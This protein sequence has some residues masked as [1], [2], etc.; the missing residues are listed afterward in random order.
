M[1]RWG[2]VL[3]SMVTLGVACS[4]NS[5]SSKDTRLASDKPSVDKS[6]AANPD[7]S[8][9]AADV[10]PVSPSG[11]LGSGSTAG[12]ADK[13]PTVGVKG[14][15]YFTA[16]MLPVLNTNCASC[17]ADPRIQAAVRGPL[18]IFSF[19]AMRS[20]LADG[21]TATGNAFF[22]K[23]R[24][25][26]SHGGGDRCP[27]GANATPCKEFSAWW[28]V[29]V[30]G[31]STGKQPTPAGLVSNISSV[32]DFG[33]VYGY[34]YNPADVKATVSV[35]FYVDGP[36][37]SGTSAGTVMANTAGDDANADGDH[38]FA[39][40]L[41]IN[42]R[43][44]KQHKLYAYGLDQN[45]QTLLTITPVTFTAYAFTA[46]GRSF[47]DAT[48]KPKLAGCAS[49]HTIAYEQQ[50]YTLMAPSPASG[51]TAANND[52]INKPA[53]ANNTKHGG[54]QRCSSVTASP[55]AELQ[56]WWKIEAGQ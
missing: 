22:L 52:L 50:Y 51:A 14:E 42:L 37:G 1:H 15:A 45:S 23:V 56:A 13:G 16:T 11:G 20:K 44:G 43:D 49:C 46:A 6:S 48:V 21:A 3:I 29:E 34:A 32:S 30:G 18:T 55:C 31:A 38:A 39:Y 7:P 10:A 12:S 19:A 35:A 33:R 47:F 41:P 24:N 4:T 54:G 5:T 28:T 2:L 8:K 53:Q 36:S 27:N 17:H 25:Q 40:D 9:P 26:V